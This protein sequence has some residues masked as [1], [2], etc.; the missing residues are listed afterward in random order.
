MIDAGAFIGRRAELIRGVIVEM[1]PQNEPH[2]RVKRNLL[3][4]LFDAV[5]H[6]A[7]VLYQ[8]PVLAADESEPE[9]DLAVVPMDDSDEHPRHPHLVIEVS[10]STLRYDRVGKRPL[11]AE[12]GFPEYWI[13]DLAKRRVEVYRGPKGDEYATCEVVEAD[14]SLAIAAF[15]DVRIAVAAMFRAVP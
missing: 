2:A 4:L 9:P 8:A 14:G 3:R 1:S 7:D 12:S 15:P 6:R 10:D 5:G 11:Y 13:V